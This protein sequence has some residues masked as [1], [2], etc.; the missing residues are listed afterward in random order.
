MKNSKGF[1]VHKDIKKAVMYHLSHAEDNSAYIKKVVDVLADFFCLSEE[2]K[3]AEYKGGDNQW[4][5]KVRAARE[6]LI[7]NHEAIYEPDEI[8]YESGKWKLKPGAMER[9]LQDKVTI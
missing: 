6:D 1:P 4:E 3:Y 7:K 9:Y 5:C 2:L 8:G